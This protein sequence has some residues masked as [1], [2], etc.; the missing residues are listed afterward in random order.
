[1]TI[2]K[3]MNTIN[4]K[5]VFTAGLPTCIYLRVLNIWNALP[6]S[7]DFTSLNKFK[8]SIFCILILMII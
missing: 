6:D 4:D 2:D 3:C 1:M 8:Q 5:Q 7:V